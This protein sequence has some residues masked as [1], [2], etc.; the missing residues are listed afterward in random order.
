MSFEM[1]NKCSRC[2]SSIHFIKFR[3]IFAFASSQGSTVQKVSP[4]KARPLAANVFKIIR[5][6]LKTFFLFVRRGVYRRLTDILFSAWESFNVSLLEICFGCGTFLSGDQF[7]PEENSLILL[8]HRTRVD[9]NF[10]WAALLHGTSPPAHNAK[11][12]L[13]DEV[14]EIPGVGN[15]HLNILRLLNS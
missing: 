15:V 3:A 12:V 4:H 11:L 14:K 5:I 6:V 2:A 1:S 10:F 13:K 9:W 8:N 7:R